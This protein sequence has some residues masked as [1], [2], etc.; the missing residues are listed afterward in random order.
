MHAAVYSWNFGPWQRNVD[1]AQRM[2]NREGRTFYV[3]VHP[4]RRDQSGRRAWA[5]WRTVTENE[6][7]DVQRRVPGVSFFDR[8][9]F[10]GQTKVEPESRGRDRSR[11]RA[12]RLPTRRRRR[13]A[14]EPEWIVIDTERG[15]R[16]VG[17]H[18]NRRT[19]AR[20]DAAERNR[21]ARRMRFAY[22]PEYAL[23]GV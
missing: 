20:D 17:R 4:F 1:A 14:Q 23:E 2:A 10:A 3:D 22:K 11:T 19:D 13:D 18:G 12:R 21:A 9:D 8:R 7:D 5:I 16:I 6:E 15:D